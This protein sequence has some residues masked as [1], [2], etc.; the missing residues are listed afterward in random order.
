MSVDQFHKEVSTGKRFKF[1]K[2]W[3]IFLTTINEE[4]IKKAELSLKTMLDVESLEGKSFLD[5]GSGSGLFSLAAK[6]LGAKVFS[7]D[8][9]DL[10]VWCTSELKSR[11]Y[12]ADTSWTIVQGSVLDD[13]FL[14]TLG[15]YDYVYSWG[16]LHHTGQMWKALDKVG[17]LVRP[18]GS[19]FIALY[20]QQRFLSRYWAFV[21]R[22]YNKFPP[23]RP[24]WIVLHLL[25]P[26]I[27]SITLRYFKNRNKERGMH[28]WYDLLDWLGGYPFEVATPKEIF[29]FYKSKGFILTELR[30]VGGSLG[31][32]EFVF[33]R[34]ICEC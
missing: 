11:F 4:R 22:S 31:C 34:R 26:T 28:V 13:D 2:N 30:T 16:V 18:N 27:P 23:I 29:N 5:I 15:Q 25:Y 1:G 24:F 10:A 19:L 32:N 20:N 21:K 17:Q 9:D 7:F 12:E 6:N 33:C 8:F 14:G 3:K